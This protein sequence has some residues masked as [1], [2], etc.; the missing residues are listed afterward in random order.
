L[1]VGTISMA[2]GVTSRAELVSMSMVGSSG[3]VHWLMIANYNQSNRRL[4]AF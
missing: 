4:L 1:P 3:S 2:R